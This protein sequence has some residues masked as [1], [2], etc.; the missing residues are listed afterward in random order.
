[1]RA[2]LKHVWIIVIIILLSSTP[3]FTDLEDFFFQPQRRVTIFVED[4]YKLYRKNL[5]A[6]R[7]AHIANIYYLKKALYAAENNKWWAHPTK[8]FAFVQ[9]DWGNPPQNFGDKYPYRKIDPPFT[10][11]HH[12][13]YREVM[14]MRICLLLTKSF[15]NLGSRYD[16]E[17]IYFFNS[18]NY[19]DL[20][21]LDKKKKHH[22]HRSFDLAEGYY[23]EALKYWKKTKDY[24]KVCWEGKYKGP[25]ADNDVLYREIDLQGTEVDQM[26]DEIY[27]IYHGG[28]LKG[29]AED[30]KY[31]QKVKRFKEEEMDYFNK[32][33][34]PEFNYDKVI[35]D[36]LNDLEWKRKKLDEV[37]K[38]FGTK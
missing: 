21:Y 11:A 37:I 2:V 22:T 27:K 5:Y 14:K 3:A 6:D 23:K 15:L 35:Q 7:A 16:R 18:K 20:P 25:E 28:N 1:M 31:L 10:L 13:K 12:A 17:N 32:Q 30:P 24:V 19:E 38:L 8:C 36:K 26:E 4:Y 34:Y 9:Y 33:N 29:M